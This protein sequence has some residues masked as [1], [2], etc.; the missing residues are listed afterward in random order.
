[1]PFPQCPQ[2]S[3]V[4]N[5]EGVPLWLAMK[6]DKIKWAAS[7][8]GRER[9]KLLSEEVGSA[10]LCMEPDERRKTLPAYAGDP[11]AELCP[12]GDSEPF[13]PESLVPLH[14]IGSGGQ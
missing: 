1:V 13:F 10:P 12:L 7:K 2:A 14:G 6:G 11:T 5:T 3:R 8:G 9:S 4:K